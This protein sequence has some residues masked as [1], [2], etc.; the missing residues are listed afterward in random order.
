MYNHNFVVRMCMADTYFFFILVKYILNNIMNLF[1]T[2][3]EGLMSSNITFYFI[4]YFNAFFFYYCY[5]NFFKIMKV[6]F[7]KF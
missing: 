7:H 2:Y 6:T 3:V 1:G 5:H 4:S